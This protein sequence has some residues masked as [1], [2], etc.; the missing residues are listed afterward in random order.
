[1]KLDVYQ[2]IHGKK[3][4]VLFSPRWK[5]RFPTTGETVSVPT[6]KMNMEYRTYKILE[7]DVVLEQDI[8]NVWS[9]QVLNVLVEE[10]LSDG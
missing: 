2:D 6:S 3:V 8:H 9:T 4:N 10:V 5:G 7:V 1:M